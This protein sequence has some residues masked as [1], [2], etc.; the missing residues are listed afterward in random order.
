MS[1][2]LWPATDTKNAPLPGG[3]FLL[4]ERGCSTEGRRFTQFLLAV[5]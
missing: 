3:A 5:T 1:A 4:S 2:D